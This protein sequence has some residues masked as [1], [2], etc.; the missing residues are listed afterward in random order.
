MMAYLDDEL[1]ELAALRFELRLSEEPEL[2]AEFETLASVDAQQRALFPG[3]RKVSS[4]PWGLRSRAGVRVAALLVATLG[5]V[6]AGRALFGP[7][8]GAGT[9]P[10]PSLVAGGAPALRFAAAALPFERQVQDEIARTLGAEA[11]RPTL[12]M[13]LDA[14]AGATADAVSPYADSIALVDALHAAEE[15]RAR[16]ALAEPVREL[17]AGH[18]AL[19]V[20]VSAPASALVLRRVAG[21]RLELLGGEAAAPVF[22]LEPGDPCWLPAPPVD[23][24]VERLDVPEDAWRRPFLVP[25]DAGRMEVLL[26]V[27]GGAV[28]ASLLQEL[29][30]RLAGGEDPRAWLEAEGFE[31]ESFLVHEPE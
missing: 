3:A 5:L 20:E 30:A 1:E 31:L 4:G 27:R 17:W 6:L 7:A 23:R 15:Q 9:P 28:E 8:A 10:D 29:Q 13:A 2:A 16:A 26:A 11:A 14:T 21:A 24:T 18:F 22:S 19:A 12:R 25:R